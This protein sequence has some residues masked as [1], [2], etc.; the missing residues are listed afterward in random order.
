MENSNELFGQPNILLTIYSDF[1]TYLFIS[2]HVIFNP[3]NNF[4]KKVNYLHFTLRSGHNKLYAKEVVLSSD[5]RVFS[6][7]LSEFQPVISF[8]WFEPEMGTRC[9]RISQV[10]LIKRKTDLHDGTQCPLIPLFCLFWA[11][12]PHSPS[13][14]HKTFLFL[15]CSGLGS[16]HESLLWKNSLKILP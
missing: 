2:L 14:L 9:L 10:C 8:Q 3:F 16:A 1:S 13:S 7:Y 4:E 5:S 15:L 6:V 12:E 11:T